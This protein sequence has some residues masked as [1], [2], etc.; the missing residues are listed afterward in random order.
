MSRTIA[1]DFDGV[2]ST[3]ENGWMGPVPT[4]PPVIG[5]RAGLAALKAMGYGVVVFSCRA[6]THE[7]RDGIKRWLRDWD[8]EVDEVTGIKPHASL[9]LDDRAMRFDGDWEA[10]VRALLTGVPRPWNAALQPP[11]RPITE[12]AGPTCGTC[13]GQVYQVTPEGRYVACGHAIPGGEAIA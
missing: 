6:L 4:D 1:V 2:I 8:I 10:V 3:Y 13:G 11:E 12:V 7:G 5:A 9:Y